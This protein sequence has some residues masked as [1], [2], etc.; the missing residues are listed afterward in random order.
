M[1]MT[2]PAKLKLRTGCLARLPGEMRIHTHIDQHLWHNV[3]FPRV[4]SRAPEHA[5][6]RRRRSDQHA[7]RTAI[8][9]T[10]ARRRN[11]R[12]VNQPG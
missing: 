12:A 8:R 11:W 7:R 3:R 5:A 4:I 10:T 2:F 6:S 9:D 1:V